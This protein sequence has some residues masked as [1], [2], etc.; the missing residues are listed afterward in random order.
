M[1]LRQ[2]IIQILPIIGVIAFV[3][4]FQAES[5]HK[6][7]TLQAFGLG[8]FVAHFYLLSA[9]TGAILSFLNIGI[10]I[11][12]I[13]KEKIRLFRKRIVLFLALLVLITATGISWEG[14][15]SIFA[16]LALVLITLAKWQRKPQDIR[17][18]AMLSGLSW[19]TYDAFVRSYGGIVSE[20]IILISEI[21]SF[22]RNRKN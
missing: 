17:R 8:F 7:L 19:I 11:V 20:S 13:L 12:F 1:E 2:L 21:V 16:L 15:H 3:I 4:S 14:F 18:V 5:R 6:I 9:W 10:T 22:T